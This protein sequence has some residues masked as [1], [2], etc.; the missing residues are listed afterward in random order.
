M[1]FGDHS[2]MLL[3]FVS[4]VII[5]FASALIPVINIE[6]YV[7]F[8][9]SVAPRPLL[10]ALLITATLSHMAGKSLMYLAARGFERLPAGRLKDRVAAAKMKLEQ[11]QS[12]GSAV[13]LV[14][15]VTGIPPFYLTS[16]AAGALR[17]NFTSFFVMGFLG[18]LLRFAALIALPQVARSS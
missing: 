18:R 2:T 15:A 10:P 12:L 4:T 17:F 3:T 9:G 11:R 8:L 16:V 1:N 6:V 14:S 13:V 5:C 7:I